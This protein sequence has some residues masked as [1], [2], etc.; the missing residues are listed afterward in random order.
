[1]I[2]GKNVLHLYK[3]NLENMKKY[4]IL[5]ILA[6]S[7]LSLH[8]QEVVQNLGYQPKTLLKDGGRPTGGYF[9]MQPKV[10]FFA[11]QVSILTGASMAMVLGHQFNIGLAGYVLTS[12]VNVDYFLFNSIWQTFAYNGLLEFA[13]VGIILEP[14]FFNR[15]VVHFTTPLI[16]GPGVGSLGNKRI[17]DEGNNIIRSD[18][19]WVVEPGLNL[20]LNITKVL[21]FNAGASYRFVFDSDLPQLSDRSL[22]D[23]AFTAGLKIGWY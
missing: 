18:L 14:V 12:D 13:Y 8:A 21:R 4:I 9:A 17:W 6:V 5:A 1:L 2:S 3:T 23:I 20:E 15:S 10:T 19:F 7:M 11:D 16:A 22:S